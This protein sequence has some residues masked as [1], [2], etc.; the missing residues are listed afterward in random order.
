M[1]QD[2]CSIRVLQSLLILQLVD[3]SQAY[4]RAK[5][6]SYSPFSA[7]LKRAFC[8]ANNFYRLKICYRTVTLCVV[9]YS[10]GT[11]DNFTGEAL[12]KILTA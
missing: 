3:P 2:D 4:S 10:D 12:E 9:K 6:L 5:Y 8:F 7:T 11:Q 1:Y